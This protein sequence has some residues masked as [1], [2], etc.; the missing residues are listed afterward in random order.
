[1]GAS[2]FC[3][4]LAALVLIATSPY[5]HAVNHPGPNYLVGKQ[6]FDA[7]PQLYRVVDGGSGS[8]QVVLGELNNRSPG[9][10][11]NQLWTLT[12]AAEIQSFDNSTLCLD[13][14]H[15]QFYA[16]ASVVSWQ[17]HGGANQ[18]WFVEADSNA[19]LP[20]PGF[21]VVRPESFPELCLDAK[22]GNTSIGAELVLWTCIP[23]Q[24]NQQ[25][26]LFSGGR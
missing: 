5:V 15:R 24:R 17:C 25:W 26:A 19:T 21:G 7:L 1:M 20:A 23:H 16:G 18:K 3:T 12:D 13:V 2:G 14:A 6:A 9:I 8:Q 10:G 22:G 4:T 11:G